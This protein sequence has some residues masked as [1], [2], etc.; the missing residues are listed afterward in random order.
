[1]TTLERLLADRD[2]VQALY[3]HASIRSAALA[4]FTE[5][6]DDALQNL[7]VDEALTVVFRMDIIGRNGRVRSWRGNQRNMP[8][9]AAWRQAVY[10]RDGFRCQE[11]GG[12]GP[13]NAHHVRSWAGFPELRFD[14]ENGITLCLACH[15]VRHPQMRFRRYGA[16]N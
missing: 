14:V 7:Q 6:L 4:S 12:E 2:D 15:E 13:L 8:E 9:Y 16:K 11:C 1:M 5:Q 10:E 3:D